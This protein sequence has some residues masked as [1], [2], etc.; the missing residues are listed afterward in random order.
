MTSSSTSAGTGSAWV[1]ASACVAAGTGSAWVVAGI[2][3]AWVAAGAGGAGTWSSLG[4]DN[5]AQAPDNVLY[6]TVNGTVPNI[7]LSR[8][9]EGMFFDGVTVGGEFRFH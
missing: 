9:E 7:R 3:S 1:A 8:H 5:L 2:C 6:D 4:I